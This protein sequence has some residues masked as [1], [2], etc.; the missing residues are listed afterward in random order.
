MLEIEVGAAV[1]VL[2]VAVA[3]V[4]LVRFAEFFD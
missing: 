2:I 1:A 3:V 4:G